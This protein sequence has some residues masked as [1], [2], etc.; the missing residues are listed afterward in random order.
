MT[1][2]TFSTPQTR[3]L[4]NFYPHKPKGDKHPYPVR[5]V[6]KEL[7]F[8][9]VENAYQAAKAKNPND[10]MQFVTMTPF[11][12]KAFVE[13]GHM[14]IRSDWDKVKIHV[15]TDLVRQKF[16]HSA[17][18]AQLLLK[19]GSQELIEGNTWGDIFW[20][21]CNGKGK[22]HLG[23]ILMQIRQELSQK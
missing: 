10:R 13:A 12:A 8:D 3:F 15:M 21:V 1:I 18:L 2:E 5:V 16:T 9:C 11:E 22:N 6:Y 7:I 14:E 19:T 20:G 17:E 23:K 4:S